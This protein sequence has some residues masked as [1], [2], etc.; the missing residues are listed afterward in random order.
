MTRTSENSAVNRRVRILLH[1]KAAARQD[2]RD[3]VNAVRAEGHHIEVRVTW[4]AGDTQRLVREAVAEGVE[5]VVA[6]GGDGTINEVVTGLFQSTPSIDT[7]PSL[8]ILPLG[9]ANDFAR[10]CHIPL[11][12][13]PAL[14]L[15]VSS[16]PSPMDIV[17]VGDRFL[18]NVA[19]G[20]FGPK[21]TVETSEDL[22]K[23]LGGAAYFVTGVT[24]LKTLAAEKAR[25]RGPG[26]EWSGAY[27]ILAI[28]NARQAGGGNVLC[29]EA[30]I[31]DGLLDVRILPDI[32]EAER[33][34][35]LQELLSEGEA[36]IE[37]R[38][39]QARIPW[40]EIEA[41]EPLHINLDGEP[42]NEKRYRFE[43]DAGSLRL[44]LPADAPV[45]TKK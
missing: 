31:N 17:R 9:T 32:P 34:Q 10:S 12:P 4:E 44:H 13:A 43:I 24:K 38:V 39:V 33:N 22:K 5:A 25:F 29:P 14:G 1:G 7:R 28:G 15:V 16:A 8:G 23:V 35:A 11:D 19:T 20:G 27:P 26:F 30:L 42:M 21:I 40:V 41:D 3:A 2:I 6:G 37:R 45:V 36:A 18:I